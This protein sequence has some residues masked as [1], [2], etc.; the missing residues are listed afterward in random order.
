MASQNFYLMALTNSTVQRA[1]LWALSA[2]HYVNLHDIRSCRQF[3]EETLKPSVKAGEAAR[4][5]Q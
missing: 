5:G 2:K 4:V 3:M 1:C